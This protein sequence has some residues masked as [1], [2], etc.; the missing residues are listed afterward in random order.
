MSHIINSFSSFHFNI[1]KLFAHVSIALGLITT[2]ITI[3]FFTYA[4]NIE[5]KI[6]IKN[7]EYIVDDFS[8][9]IFPLLSN[10]IKLKLY[11]KIKD[12]K[13][14]DM[15]E[16]DTF[17]ENS[18][19]KLVSKS[20]NLILVIFIISILSSYIICKIYN[21]DFYEI[22]ITNIFLACA[23]MITEYI[24]LNLVIFNWILADPNQVKA[25]IVKSFSNFE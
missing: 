17:V 1:P 4:K 18:N 25:Q 11:R 3:F 23:V 14:P 12:Y 6:I 8:E 10:N 15:T 20:Y 2:F 21:L 24:F 9:D 13:L 7:V 22:L 5:K 19:K 16:A